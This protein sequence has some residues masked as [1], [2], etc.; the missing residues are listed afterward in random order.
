MDLRKAPADAQPNRASV[1]K[2]SR[3]ACPDRDG[4]P[5]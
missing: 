2:T 5:E 1:W 3:G 4:A